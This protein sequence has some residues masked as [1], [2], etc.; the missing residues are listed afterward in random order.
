VHASSITPAAKKIHQGGA[1]RID[2]REVIRQDEDGEWICPKGEERSA[3]MWA[4]VLTKEECV[5]SEEARDD[6]EIR[7][8]DEYIWEVQHL[9]KD[10]IASNL[11]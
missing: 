4:G 8:H 3:S 6:H 2:R 11:L 7:T 9:P 10:M 5:H 1:P